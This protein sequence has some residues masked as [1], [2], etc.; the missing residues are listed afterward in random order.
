MLLLITGASGMGKS[1]V[2]TLLSPALAPEVESVE[3]G[4]VVPVPAWPDLAWRQRAAEKVVQRALEREAEGR[5]LLLA[6]D[7]VAPGEVVAAPS[8]DRLAGIR[9]CLLDAT[10]ERQEERLQGRGDPVAL[11][12]DHVAFAGWMRAH[13]EDPCHM[14]E[15]LTRGGWEEMRWERW[16]ERRQG[17]LGWNVARIDTTELGIDEVAAAALAWAR[18]S[19]RGETAPLVAA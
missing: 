7:P 18:A 6:G 1:S 12:P 8:A 17:D 19:L 4:G 3:L 9:A 13:A 16:V 2:R 5:H 10:A 14:P 11:L 15:V